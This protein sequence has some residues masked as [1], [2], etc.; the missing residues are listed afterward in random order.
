[1]AKDMGD[2]KTVDLAPLKLFKCVYNYVGPQGMMR[3]GTRIISARDEI[4]ARGIL[5][6]Q[7]RDAK[8]AAEVRSV[9][10]WRPDT[11]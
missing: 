2:T 5:L 10:V 6:L 7:M 11:E 3:S 4:E 1:M 9:L 8:L